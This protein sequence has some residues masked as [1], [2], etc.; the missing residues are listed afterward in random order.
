MRHWPFY[1]GRAALQLYQAKLFLF[2]SLVRSCLD[3]YFQFAI[4]ETAGPAYAMGLSEFSAVGAGTQFFN[5]QLGILG[6]AHIAA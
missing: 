1:S 6:T 3:G 4:I 5:I 2:L